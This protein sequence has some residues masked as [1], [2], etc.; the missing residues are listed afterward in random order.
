MQEG[1]IFFS[2][3]DAGRTFN[4]ILAS[5]NANAKKLEDSIQ[6]SARLTFMLNSISCFMSLVGFAAQVGEHLNER[7]AKSAKKEP[8]QNPVT[9]IIGT[10]PIKETTK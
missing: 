7:H 5:N 8:N 4:L 1:K 10:E 9:P 3:I 6:E 2:G